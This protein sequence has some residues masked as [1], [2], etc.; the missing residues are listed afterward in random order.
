MC[1]KSFYPLLFEKYNM[2]KNFISE[3]ERPYRALRLLLNILDDYIN[4]NIDIETQM[5][6]SKKICWL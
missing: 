5:L 4:G 6:K 1:S 3:L 2:I